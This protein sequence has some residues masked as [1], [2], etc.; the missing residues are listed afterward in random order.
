MDKYN[1]SCAVLDAMIDPEPD[2]LN[3]GHSP[4]ILPD[5]NLYDTSD[6]RLTKLKLLIQSKTNACTRHEEQKSVL[7][8][9]LKNTS[10]SSI[11][12]AE[13]GGC[14]TNQFNTSVDATQL[15]ELTTEILKANESLRNQQIDMTR[16]VLNL[17]REQERQKILTTDMESMN[18]ELAKFNYEL[19]NI[20]IACN[21]SQKPS[22]FSEKLSASKTNLIRLQQSLIQTKREIDE[23]SSSISDLKK[24]IHHNQTTLFELQSA[25]S[26]HQCLCDIFDSYRQRSEHCFDIDQLDTIYVEHE[27]LLRDCMLSQ[28]KDKAVFEMKL[29]KVRNEIDAVVSSLSQIYE[30]RKYNKNTKPHSSH[31]DNDDTDEECGNIPSKRRK[32]DYSETMLSKLDSIFSESEQQYRNELSKETPNFEHLYETLKQQISSFLDHIRATLAAPNVS[33]VSSTTP[34]QHQLSCDEPQS[35]PYHVNLNELRTKE[36][37]ILARISSIDQTL[38]YFNSIGMQFL[39]IQKEMS[40]DA[41]KEMK[42]KARLAQLNKL[43][44]DTNDEFTNESL[45]V[46]ELEGFQEQHDK[47]IQLTAK[48]DMLRTSVANLKPLLES[49]VDYVRTLEGKKSTLDYSIDNLT[50]LI[51]KHEKERKNIEHRQ[52]I[53]KWYNESRALTQ[54]IMNDKKDIETLSQELNEVN[55]KKEEYAKWCILNDKWQKHLSFVSLKNH[56]KSDIQ[57]IKSLHDKYCNKLDII[58]KAMDV[59]LKSCSKTMDDVLMS[60]N[61]HIDVIMKSFFPDSDDSM[62]VEIGDD[63]KRSDTKIIHKGVNCSI[64]SL[65]TGEEARVRIAIDMALRKVAQMYNSS[66][67]LYP[68]ILDE[69]VANLNE[70]LART[71]IDTIRQH[72]VGQTLIFAAHQIDEGCFENVEYINSK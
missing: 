54:L 68:L 67:L 17:H 70:E 18:A 47:V 48:I 49:V 41:S 32:L 66:S 61:H 23:C 27:N 16:L 26:E 56:R 69:G 33:E 65:S 34:R 51:S 2:A 44:T 24:R 60:L 6:T 31:D 36:K 43:F 7:D 55:A 40:L 58:N 72:F 37:T 9:C 22:D 46:K 45:T 19:T 63:G 5:G 64:S 20:Q 11:C 50:L 62:V 28:S 10:C 14:V 39:A 53:T 30:S 57:E 52:Q 8:T 3:P 42:N 35:I 21:L 25:S 59:V 13:V 4:L 12:N 1:I 71:V 38:A 15:Q 29:A